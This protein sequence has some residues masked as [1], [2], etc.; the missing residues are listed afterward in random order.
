MTAA[1]TALFLLTPHGAPPADSFR[2]GIRPREGITYRYRQMLEATA[3][4]DGHTAKPIV[5]DIVQRL[6]VVRRNP[7]GFEILMDTESVRLQMP[8]QV[9]VDDAGMRKVEARMKAM[10]RLGATFE[11]N[12]K[13]KQFWCTTGKDEPNLPS[14]MLSVCFAFVA[15]ATPGKTVKVGDSWT[16]NLAASDLVQSM[17]TQ[18]GVVA[19][20]EPLHTAWTVKS[21]E[22]RAGREVAVVTG[23]LSGAISFVS[24]GGAPRLSTRMS[25]S[26][27]ST[28]VYD[29]ATGMLIESDQ[30]ISTEGESASKPGDPI[31]KFGNRT[32]SKITQ[33][34]N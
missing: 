1:L 12:G 3:V 5:R 16:E 14:Q 11:P 2:F 26:S 20:G 33:L 13:L 8:P 32:H 23:K 9:G 7:A 34:G 29:C 18:A 27:E 24:Q 25:V 28:A 4:Y 19:P 30:S 22:K 6:K 17:G 10:L 21:I 31:H 15:G